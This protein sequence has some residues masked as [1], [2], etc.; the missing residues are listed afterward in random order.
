MWRHL[1]QRATLLFPDSD[2]AHLGY[3]TKTNRG[4][5]PTAVMAADGNPPRSSFTKTD[6]TY[7]ICRGG[8]EGD[9]HGFFY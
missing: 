8:G 9:L 2:L 3:I 4:G 1:R 7:I 5:L 6:R